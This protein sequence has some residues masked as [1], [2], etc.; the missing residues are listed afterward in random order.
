[1]KSKN[2]KNI[3][4]DL[5]YIPKIED[6]PELKKIVEDLEKQDKQSFFIED[7]DKKG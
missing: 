1:M 3:K 7:V 2:S 6:L 5:N 4:E